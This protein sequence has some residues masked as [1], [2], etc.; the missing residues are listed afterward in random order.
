MFLQLPVV[1]VHYIALAGYPAIFALMV[2]E[3]A[4]I[5][6]PSEIT[7]PFSGFLVSQGKLDFWLV[8]LIG[9]SG[10]LVGSL[11]AF[12]LG[13][14][15]R[16]AGVR[17][18]IKKYGK[19]LLISGQDYDRAVSWFDRHGPPIAFFSRVLPVVRTFISLPAGVART[20]VFSFAV[21]TFAGSLLWSS[22]LA[23]LGYQLGQKWPI[24]GVYFHRF[25]AAVLIVLAL[26]IGYY[27][28]H[29]TK[30]L[31]RPED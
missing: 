4:L 25:D 23:A 27:V 1:L 6:I 13:W 14:V 8:V 17:D 7:M 21:Y 16:D 11:L 31:R 22:V 18:W 2:A 24:L 10:N 19:F 3:S 12:G 26:G 9:A 15:V 28:F 29:K 30:K 5:P 20:N